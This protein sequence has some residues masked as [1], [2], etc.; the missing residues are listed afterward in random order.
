VTRF[1]ARA[2]PEAIKPNATFQ[3]GAIERE[4]G[5]LDYRLDVRSTDE[6]GTDESTIDAMIGKLIANQHATP[7]GETA[8]AN[9]LS[10]RMRVGP[11]ERFSPRG[12]LVAPAS[13]SCPRLASADYRARKRR[14]VR[15]RIACRSPLGLSSLAWCAIRRKSP[16][17]IQRTPRQGAYPIGRPTRSARRSRSLRRT[18]R[19]S[20]SSIA[21]L[22]NPRRHFVADA[23]TIRRSRGPTADGS[24]GV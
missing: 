4:A 24:Y 9:A 20:P 13:T 5:K 22:M 15:R 21:A 3:N 23:G 14:R 11:P 7:K 8:E 17:P 19:R 12:P 10:S 18:C 16:S 2:P 1:E 6:S